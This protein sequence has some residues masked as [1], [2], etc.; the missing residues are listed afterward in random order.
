MNIKY[1]NNVA[2]VAAAATGAAT[3]ATAAA[4]ASTELQFAFLSDILLV[5]YAIALPM[6]LL[7]LPCRQGV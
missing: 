1:V 7:L 3:T 2:I 4:A 6:L 5:L